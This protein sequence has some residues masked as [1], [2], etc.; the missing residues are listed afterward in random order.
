[1]PNG[2]PM[3]EMRR[4]DVAMKSAAGTTIICRQTFFFMRCWI[5]ASSCRASGV[6]FNAKTAAANNTAKIVDLNMIAFQPLMPEN[7]K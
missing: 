2:L 6:R 5:T 7:K 3:N 1:M 4:N